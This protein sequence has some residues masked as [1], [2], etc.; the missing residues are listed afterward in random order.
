MI[1]MEYHEMNFDFSLVTHWINNLKSFSQE[2]NKMAV[3][4]MSTKIA[5]DAFQKAIVLFLSSSRQIN[6]RESRRVSKYLKT[7]KSDS[8]V[9]QS[10]SSK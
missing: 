5:E 7:P 10:F 1:N 6:S 3:K 8:S 2:S 9:S 4:R